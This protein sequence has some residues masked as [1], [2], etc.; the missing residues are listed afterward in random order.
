MI[1]IITI[2]T[3]VTQVWVSCTNKEL[4]LRVSDFLKLLIQTYEFA[5][6]HVK[7]L[8]CLVLTLYKQSHWH[9]GSPRFTIHH[10]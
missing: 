4:A 5:L 1:H 7:V 2:T 8:F 3:G 10:P 6:G 9:P